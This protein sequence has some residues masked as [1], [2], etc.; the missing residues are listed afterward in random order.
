MTAS[1]PTQTIDVNI[2]GR[3][4]LTLV[5][6]DAGDG[7]NSDHGDWAGAR[8]VVLPPPR[9]EKIALSNGA[10][11]MGGFYGV[12]FSTYRVLTSTNLS[13]PLNLWT[14]LATNSCDV[15]GNFAF[16]NAVDPWL[17]QSFYIL[18]LP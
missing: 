3:N 8:I 11:K 4:T 12:P 16:T 2:A 17:A 10:V 1:S 5:V 13:L 14:P 7:F 9:I 15:N 18:Q 6:T